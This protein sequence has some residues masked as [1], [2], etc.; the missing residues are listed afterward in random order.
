VITAT[1]EGVV[2]TV[3]QP[4]QNVRS[5]PGDQ[6]EILGQ[7]TLGEQATVIGANLDYSWVV[8]NFRGRQGWLATYLVDITGDLRSVPEI[9]IPPAP[10]P[11]VTA[12][13]TTPPTVDVIID[14]VVASPTPII[15]GQNFTIN[16]TVRNIGNSP[17]GTFAVGG[18]FPPNTTYLVANVPPLQ[19]GQSVIVPL[20]GILTQGG[21]Y[22]TSL[23]IDVNN[24]VQEGVVGE[25]NNIYN[26]TY[27]VDHQIIRQA[28]QTLNLGDTIDLEG[29]NA[30]GD[31]NW[32][33]D[34]GVLGLKGIFGARLGVLGGGDF[35]AI[36]Y[37]LINPSVINRDTIPRTE[38]A[39][40]TILGILTA[41]G[42]RGVMQVNGV[43]DT[44]ITL[45]FRVY[46]G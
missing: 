13:P 32:N 34:G 5:G 37:D 17:A 12:T 10:T 22:T 14:S 18:T 44:Q 46:N 11:N 6:Y 1:P 19:A 40:G 25:Q 38:M 27:T 29:N 45:T 28:S 9:P 7:L 26:F 23:T 20:T 41:D 2:L 24:Q 21:T 42:H 39:A 43:S 15:A 4:V 31:A 33:S 8:I 16:I 3:T 30:Q 35:N 36:N